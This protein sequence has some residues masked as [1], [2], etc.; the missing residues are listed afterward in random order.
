MRDY[1]KTLFISGSKYHNMSAM[2]RAIGEQKLQ[3]TLYIKFK[4]GEISFTLRELFNEAAL[5]NMDPNLAVVL[6]Q[7]V[8]LGA[9]FNITPE[10]V[11]EPNLDDEYRI[12]VNP[13]MEY[14]FI[15]RFD[16]ILKGI[17]KSVSQSSGEDPQMEQSI[18]Q[19]INEEDKLKKI[20]RVFGILVEISLKGAH[21]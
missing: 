20:Q 16:E 17:L 7:N 10:L 9:L 3:C 5:A 6:L 2:E 14:S 19:T 11:D 12:N 1:N 18:Q 4:K 15:S 8:T 21:N 13:M